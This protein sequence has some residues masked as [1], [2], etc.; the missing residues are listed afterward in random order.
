MARDGLNAPRRSVGLTLAAYPP[1]LLSEAGVHRR[2]GM[3]PTAMG[4]C[5]LL[6]AARTAPKGKAA[7][8]LSRLG[9]DNLGHRKALRCAPYDRFGLPAARQDK[10]ADEVACTVD[11]DPLCVAP[12]TLAVL[13]GNPSTILG[14]VI[15][16]NVNAVD[17]EAIGARPHVGD[18]GMEVATP[19][20][21][22]A[23][24]SSPIV[25][26]RLRSR[27]PASVPHAHPCVEK[28][29]RI[30]KRHSGSPCEK[31]T[32]AEWKGKTE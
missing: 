21:A 26:E 17:H 8:I 25:L 27:V 15:P 24:T 30:F 23:N 18:K 11:D 14:R 32:S 29:M 3:P 4:P 2:E 1:A 12:I 5:L 10:F 7:E 22:N 19:P 13:G 6:G 31:Y 28:G 16:V 20:L 9:G